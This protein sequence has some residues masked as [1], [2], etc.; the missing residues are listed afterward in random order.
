MK[1]NGIT[2]IIA[3]AISAIVSYCLYSWCKSDNQILLDIGSFVYCATTL[4]F[5]MS[6]SF[7][8]KRTTTNIRFLS[9]TFLALGII[10]NAIFTFVQFGSPIYILINGIML[11]IWLAI[12]YFIKKADM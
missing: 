6:V 1:V 3:L 7:E 9:G 10:S 8:S 11:L 5:T 2:T 12:T 4:I